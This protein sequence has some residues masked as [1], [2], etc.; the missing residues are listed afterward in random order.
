M[1]FDYPMNTKFASIRPSMIYMHS[2]PSGLRRCVQVAVSSD[3]GVRIPQNALIDDIFLFFIFFY[4][5]KSNQQK[6]IQYFTIF[7]HFLFCSNMKR[8]HRKTYLSKTIKT[9]II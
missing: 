3:A 7:L 6:V 9:K 4:E 8:T 1:L 2:W 5:Y